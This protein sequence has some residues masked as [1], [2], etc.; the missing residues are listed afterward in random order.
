MLL[1]HFTC[2]EC[3]P[4]ILREGLSRGEV[5]YSATEVG[6]AVNLTVDSMPEGNGVFR[7]ALLTDEERATFARIN[8]RAEP[9]QGARWPDKTAVRISVEIPSSDCKLVKWEPFARRRLDPEWLAALHEG[10]KPDGW[11]LY[12]GTIPPSN[13]TEVCERDGDSYQQIAP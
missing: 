3:L 9:P 4:T 11:W 1:Y 8:N 13:F 7:G 5:P 6:N 12:F 10:Q 2:V